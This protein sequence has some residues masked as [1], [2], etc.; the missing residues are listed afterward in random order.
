MIK[1]LF[2][3]SHQKVTCPKGHKLASSG[4][5]CDKVI[6]AAGYRLVGSVCKKLMCPVGKEVVGHACRDIECDAGE[7][8]EA[9]V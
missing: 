8:L 1:V 3:W 7:K 9:G 6:C 4:H 5:D 2:P